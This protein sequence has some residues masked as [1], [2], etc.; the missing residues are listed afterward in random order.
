MSSGE[1]YVGFQSE[2][3]LIVKQSSQVRILNI[4]D[5][6]EEHFVF[7]PHWIHIN[8]KEWF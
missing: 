8:I 1:K 3:R 4:N 7:P 6:P 5:K 2:S